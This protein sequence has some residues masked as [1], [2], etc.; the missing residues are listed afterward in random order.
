MARLVVLFL[1]VLCSVNLAW[2]SVGPDSLA[3]PRPSRVAGVSLGLGLGFTG[4]M[5]LLDRAW[6]AQYPR[7]AL[8]GFNDWY[9]WRQM[10]KMGHAWTTYNQAQLVTELYQWSGL[11]PRTSAYL[12]FGAAMLFQSGL[13]LLDGFSEAWGFSWGDMAFNALGGGLYLGQALV[14]K[15]QYISLKY[16][17]YPRKYD[18]QTPIYALDGSGLSTTLAQRAQNLYGSSLPQQM[19]KDYNAQT[20]W[21]SLNFSAWKHWPKSIPWLN[22]ALGYSLG[23]VFGAERNRWQVNQVWFAAPEAYRRHSVYILSLDLDWRRIK[24][25][26]PWLRT[27]FKALNYVKIPFPALSYRSYGSWHWHWLYF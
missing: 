8:H 17:F 18:A 12:G 11:G 5:Y 6:Y 3:P 10:D 4:T 27:L 14:W 21:L 7:T 20:I 23:D 16:S 24:T 1:T 22:L 25:K 2:A 15:E 13:E 19:L 9:H 26:K